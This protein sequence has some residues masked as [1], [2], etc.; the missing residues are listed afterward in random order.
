MKM[1]HPQYSYS[2]TQD[3][4]FSRITFLRK[5]GIFLLAGLL[6]MSAYSAE[7]LPVAATPAPRLLTY[8]WMPLATWYRVHADDVEIAEK[9][10]GKILFIGDSIT[11]GW[12]GWGEQYWKEYFEPLG[13]INFGIGGDMTQNVLWRLDHG[14]VG[15]LSPDEVVL[16][17]GINN[18]GFTEES[19][20]QVAVGVQLVVHKLREVF[21]SSKLLLLAVF[22]MGEFPDHPNREKVRLLNEKIQPLGDLP[23]VTYLDIGNAFLLE[24]GRIPN[25]LMGDFLHPTAA[26]YKI[27]TDAIL[28]WM[29]ENAP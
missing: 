7:D 10:E 12:N 19:P 9:G 26:G 17:I 16:L 21:S 20:D 3:T 18:F 6:S 13:A 29:N 1:C 5:I 2:S 22:P 27:M 28:K 4:T 8:G 11:A 14:A 25:E 23:D 24:D 15:K